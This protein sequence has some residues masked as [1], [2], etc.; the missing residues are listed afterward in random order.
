MDEYMVQKWNETVKPNDIVYHLGDVALNRSSIGIVRR[1]NGCKRL[2]LGNHDIF[3]FE[4]YTPYF[5]TVH[6]MRIMREEGVM[7]THIPLHIN[8]IKLGCINVHGH[9]HEKIIAEDS[10]MVLGD[11]AS[12]HPGY[13]NVSVEH[14]DYTPVSY[15]II[16]E[17]ITK[18]KEVSHMFDV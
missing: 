12:Q 15:D 6:A 17:K 4:F 3:G 5:D 16:K 13:F 14:H 7:L 9:I 10:R 18:L 8:S 1:L 11:L 2:I